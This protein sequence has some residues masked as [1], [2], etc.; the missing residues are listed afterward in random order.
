MHIK[1]GGKLSMSVTTRMDGSK[2][3]EE[4]M[5]VDEEAPSGEKHEE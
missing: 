5:N 1:P 2:I 4:N 3:D